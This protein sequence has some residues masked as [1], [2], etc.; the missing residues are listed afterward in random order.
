MGMSWSVSLVAVTVS[1][2]GRETAVQ[3]LCSQCCAT[4]S[5]PAPSLPS[6]VPQAL[7][8][9]LRAMLAPVAAARPPAAAF[10]GGQYFQG[11][12]LLRA[13]KVHALQFWAPLLHF[14]A[15]AYC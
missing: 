5:L 9:P 3:C 2:V 15:A 1:L 11:D 4:S 12:V 7:E 13:L 8:Q 10:A 6:G 14:F